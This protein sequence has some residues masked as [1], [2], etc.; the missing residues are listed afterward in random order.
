MLIKKENM[1]EIKL[2][3]YL[4]EKFYIPKI[5]TCLFI[6]FGI[7]ILIVKK[8][9]LYDIIME[10]R[11]F[12]GSDYTLLFDEFFANYDIFQLLHDSFSFLIFVYSIC[13]I[14]GIPT[15]VFKF[16]RNKRVNEIIVIVAL[17]G[18]I[19][20]FCYYYTI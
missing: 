13:I 12:L 6:A 19:K 17:I 3:E 11:L 9:Q 15:F 16:H 10:Y 8:L 4:K 2:V 18:I 14:V 20:I 5:F 1:C 7:S